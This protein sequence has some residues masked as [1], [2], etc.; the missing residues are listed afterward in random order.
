MTATVNCNL[1]EEDGIAKKVFAK[2]ETM[3][4]YA[5]ELGFPLCEISWWRSNARASK[6][7]AGDQHCSG[8]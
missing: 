7:F 3:P 6:V 2:V 5:E 8:D 4:E 1:L